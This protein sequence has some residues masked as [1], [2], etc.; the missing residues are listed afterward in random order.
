M[1]YQS[2]FQTSIGTGLVSA[3]EAGICQVDLPSYEVAPSLSN[4]SNF[5]RQAAA[6]LERYFRKERVVFDLPIDLSGLPP[7][8]RRILTLALQIPYGAVYTYGDLAKRAGCT[9]AAR[10]VGGAMAANPV[11][12]IIPCHRVV[13]ASGKLTGYSGPGGIEM[14][15]YLLS[16][17]G[18]EFR[19]ELV[20][21]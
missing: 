4:E 3:T 6:L 19:G 8:R 9:G 20:T 2:P 10:A 18:V 16:L 1:Y 15:K 12:V 21:L 5:T 14:K 7:F 11:P 13:A 17:E